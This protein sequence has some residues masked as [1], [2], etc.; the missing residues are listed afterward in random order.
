MY[1]GKEDDHR[2]LTGGLGKASDAARRLKRTSEA[3][4]G[5]ATLRRLMVEEDVF[6]KKFD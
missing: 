4:W 6:I 2:R 5:K 1:N 3:R